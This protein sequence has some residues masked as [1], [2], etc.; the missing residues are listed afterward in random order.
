L[1]K[2]LGLRELEEGPVEDLDWA[3]AAFLNYASSHRGYA[4]QR[5][6]WFNPPI[7]LTYSEGEVLPAGANE[8]IV[9]LPYAFRALA[10]A[11]PGA[12]VLDVGAAESTLAFS[13]A[14]LGYEVTALDLNPYP[15]THPRL[16]AVVADVREWSPDR[17]FDVVLC[18]STLEHI[19][20]A[21]YGGA[22]DANADAAAVQRLF[23]LTTP[24]GTLVLTVPFGAASG[25]ETQRGY[26]RADLERLLADWTIEDLTVVR[27][28]DDL[29]WS[30]DDDADDKSARRVALVTAVRPSG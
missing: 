12:S 28:E 2:S 20:L 27:R 21:V 24:D 23:E 22:A 6:L 14:S 30:P 4:A 17:T 3:G 1:L 25:D 9:E 13:L 5:G 8:R 19:G 18:I 7:S 15:L 11:E 26:E 29:T 16:K 10:R